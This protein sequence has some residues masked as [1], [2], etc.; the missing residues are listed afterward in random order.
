MA[1]ASF[2][3][4]NNGQPEYSGVNAEPTTSKGMG[5][6]YLYMGLGLLI[7][8]V[9]AL[10]VGAFFSGWLT[11]WTF[12]A[13]EM[14]NVDGTRFTVFVFVV[15]AAFIGQLIDAIVMARVLAKGKRSIWPHFVIYSAL[16]GVSLSIIIVAG[17]DF[18]VLAE[19][20]GISAVAFLAMGL[21]GYFS[22]KDLNVLGMVAFSALIMIVLIGMMFSLFY[23]L[24]PRQYMIWSMV[25]SV[26]VSLV[27]LLVVAIDTYNIKKIMSRGGATENMCLFCAYTMYCDFIIIFLR[28]LYILSYFRR[29]K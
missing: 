25:T 12:N 22:K 8:A 14:P 3:N 17:A 7:T 5:K 13:A 16:M 26:A 28:V 18:T 9:V 27:M 24:M 10:C 19:A 2:H 20:F 11:N 4:S 1:Y 29:N 15:I 21:V 23:F 6:V